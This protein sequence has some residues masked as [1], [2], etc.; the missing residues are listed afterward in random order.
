MKTYAIDYETSYTKTRGI[1]Q[2]GVRGYLS[3][4]ETDIYL[5]SVYGPDFAWVGHPKDFDWSVLDDRD[6]VSHN[7]AFDTEVFH[8]LCRRRGSDVPYLFTPAQWNCTADLAAYTQ[9]PR[10]LLDASRELLGLQLDKTVRAEMEGR[11]FHTLSA[12]DKVRWGEYALLDAKASWLLWDKFSKFWP[13]HERAVSRHTAMMGQRGIG[14]DLSKVTQGIELLKQTVWEAEQEIP[15]AGELDAK[16]KEIATVSPKAM[17]AECRR[18]GIEPPVSTDSKSEEFDAW[19]DDNAEKAPFVQAM[20]DWRKANRLLTVLE[21]FQVRTCDGRL[22]YSVKYFGAPHTGHW[23]GDN[24]LNLLNLPRKG[25]AGVDA[26]ACLVPPAGKKFVVADLSQVQARILLWLAG[27]NKMLDLI[28]SGV[29]LYEAHAR[30]TMGYSDPRPLKEV[31]PEKR[32]FA[33]MRVLQL[34]FACG[35]AKFQSSAATMYKVKMDLGRA[36]REVDDYR[37]K[38]PGITKLWKQL[39]DAARASRGGTFTCEL[40]SGRSIH[41]FKM[42]QS[43]GELTGLVELGGFRKKLYG[44]LLTQ[45]LVAGTNR[46]I[47]AEAILKIEAAGIPVVLHVHD[48]V[49]CEVDADQAEEAARVVHQIMTTPPE[50]AEGLPIGSDVKIMDFYQK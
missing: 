22:R 31:D 17:A 9:S 38:S 16:G 5:M 11:D 33:K 28:R 29:D 24:G 6:A 43:A 4:K 25:T 50:W 23:T 18:L 15:W 47:L 19:L 1:R 2:L 36:K 40:P 34:G 37:R 41:Y 10:S 8:E 27:D 30:A 20:S 49:V 3:H 39:D 14:I 45:N 35:A 46:D 12:E 26:R 7:A 42:A 32:Q 21:Q 48:E 44:G 13:E